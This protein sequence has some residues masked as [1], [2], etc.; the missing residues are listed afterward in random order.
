MK[1]MGPLIFFLFDTNIKKW[2][3]TKHMIIF[4]LFLRHTF[5]KIMEW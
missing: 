5:R 4:N 2:K 1:G 3:I